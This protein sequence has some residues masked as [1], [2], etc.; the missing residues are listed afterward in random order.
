VNFLAR[1]RARAQKLQARIA[2]AEASDPRVLEAAT[3]LEAE[4]VAV[5]LLVLDPRM[6]QGQADA[7][8]SGLECLDPA[9]HPRLGELAD[10]LVAVRQ[11]H[12]LSREDAVQLAQDPLVFANWLLRNGEVDAAVAGAVRTTSDVIRYAL[13]L[14]GPAPTVRTVSSAF[15]MCVPPFRGSSG[16][17]GEV[18]TYTDC[19]VV[20]NP[21]ASQLADIAIA[22]A[23]ARRRIVGD[24]P[25]LALLSFSTHGSGGDGGSIALVREAL[26]LIRE[27][28]PTLVVD[29]EL[30]ADAALVERVAARK[31]P[32]SR[33]AGEANV[34]VFPSLDAGNIAYKLT[35][36]L[37]GATAIGPILQ[38]LARPVSDLSR[39]A[40]ADTIFHVATL[41]A[42][43]S[44]PA[45]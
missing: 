22:A 20:P 8:A 40:D 33:V 3:R 21:T 7:R 44:R 43:Q 29:G 27:R 32:G 30:Q 23:D 38:G 13:W 41:A 37:A 11:K 9:Q 16:E 34:L 28:E 12:G 42:L 36:R 18:L 24:E 19:A 35:E 45:S 14:I 6:K 1:V 5:P 31:A 4:G 10:T 15:Y 39:G 17:E 26:G 2:F 25:R